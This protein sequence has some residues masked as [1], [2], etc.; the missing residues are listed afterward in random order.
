MTRAPQR[1]PRLGRELQRRACIDDRQ[2]TRHPVP[3]GPVQDFVHAPRHLDILGHDGP[4]LGG[5]VAKR[6]ACVQADARAHLLGHVERL[7]AYAVEIDVRGHMPELDGDA[8]V[9]ERCGPLPVPLEHR[10]GPRGGPQHA[11]ATAK[12]HV[13][14]R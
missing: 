11:A 13:A 12:A 14:V 4:R 3:V 5:L 9:L 1:L 7:D 8:Q 2:R 10:R 6:D